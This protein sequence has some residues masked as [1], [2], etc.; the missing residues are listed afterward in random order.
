MD[1]IEWSQAALEAMRIWQES[2]TFEGLCELNARFMEGKIR[3]IPGWFGEGL[4]AESE[5]IAPYLAAFDRAGFLTVASQPGLG[6]V[7]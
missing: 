6:R 4:D 1:E 5:P 7:Q 3:F 2:E